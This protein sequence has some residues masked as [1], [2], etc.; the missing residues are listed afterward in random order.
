M[1]VHSPL[2]ASHNTDHHP[3]V[4]HSI[5]VQGTRDLGTSCIAQTKRLSART[6]GGPDGCGGAAGG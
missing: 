3:E 5:T 2:G 4:V 1:P 6:E